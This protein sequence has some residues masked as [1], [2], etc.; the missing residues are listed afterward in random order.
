MS[1]ITVALWL[2]MINFDGRG[3]Q[4]NVVAYVNRQEAAW[5]RLSSRSSCHKSDTLN[6]S[7]IKLS[8]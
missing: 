3:C 2:V 6:M 5:Q 8:Q 4:S 7:V 1:L